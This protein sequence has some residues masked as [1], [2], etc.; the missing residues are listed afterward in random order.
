MYLID[1]NSNQITPINEKT[2]SELGF[3]ERKHLQEWLAKYPLALGEELLIIQKEFDGFQDTNERLDLL[4]L[5]KQ[6]ALVLIENKLDDTGRDVTWQALKYAS[7]CSSMSKEQIKDV[8]Q[9]Y[10]DKQADNQELKKDAADKLTEFFGKDYEELVLNRM[11]TQRIMLVAGKFRKEVTSTVL[12]LSN[13]KLRM[14]CFKVTPFELNGQ[15]F[16]TIDQIIPTKDAEEY[17][18]SMANKVQEEQNTQEKEAARYGFRFELW[19]EILVKLQGKTPIFQNIN[20]QKIH[21]LSSGAGMSGVVYQMVMTKNVVYTALVFARN[22]TEENKTLF[23]EMLK[24]KKEI[25]EQFGRELQWL[26]TENNKSSRIAHELP[27]IN[28]FDLANK[29]EIVAFLIENIVR[30]EQVL[31][32]PLEK[33]KVTMKQRVID[34]S[35]D[36]TQ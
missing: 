8:Y 34:N 28:V 26:L 11:Q 18:I 33:L 6:G 22:N 24:S 19:K 35:E 4:A 13:F 10:L 31:R 3:T 9:Q 27:N 21:Y 1:K 17:M 12:W 32:K 5:D 36:E 30:L 7:Y 20:P 15:F 25:E 14:Q 29:D 23:N 16:L 2:F